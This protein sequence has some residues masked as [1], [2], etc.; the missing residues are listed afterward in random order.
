MV[1]V[2]IDI[3]AS[4]NPVISEIIAMQCFIFFGKKK[5]KCEKLHSKVAFFILSLLKQTKNPN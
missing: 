1:V 5:T 4:K 3:K 2:I